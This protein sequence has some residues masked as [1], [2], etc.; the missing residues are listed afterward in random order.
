MIKSLTYSEYL[1]Q[2]ILKISN[3]V[4]QIFYTFTISILGNILLILSSKINFKIPF[5]MIPFTMQTFAVLFL[6]ML[7]GRKVLYVL[8][9]YIFEGILGFPVFSQGGGIFYI[10]G[11]TGG[12]ILGFFVAG[13]VCGK[14]AEYGFDKSFIKT[15]FSMFLGNLIIYLF[16]ILWL[17]RFVNFDFLKALYIGVFPF[18]I[19]DI[20][21]IIFASLVLP[22]GWKITR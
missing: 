17:V 1:S 14:L 5:T 6:S 20:I 12:Y 15:F 21:K 19:G 2:K 16:G 18:I 22:L 10:L 3:P 11:P 9:L 8:S 7:L 13:Y 4:E